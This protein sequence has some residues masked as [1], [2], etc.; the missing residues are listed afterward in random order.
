MGSE[1]HV[2]CGIGRVQ[3]LSIVAKGKPDLSRE[4]KHPI[5]VGDAL[6]K[7]TWR[8]KLRARGL[9]TDPSNRSS[10]EIGE[11]IVMAEQGI[12]RDH[13]EALW[14][15]LPRS[16]VFG[17]EVIVDRHVRLGLDVVVTVFEVKS[18]IPIVAVVDLGTHVGAGRCLSGS[19]IPVGRESICPEDVVNMIAAVHSRSKDRIDALRDQRWTT[20]EDEERSCLGGDLNG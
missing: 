15:W 8:V 11:C 18:R 1:T 5:A 7:N 12:A 13:L 20:S 17:V 6:R 9:V 16:I 3:F 4:T 14:E 10:A 2:S 19:I